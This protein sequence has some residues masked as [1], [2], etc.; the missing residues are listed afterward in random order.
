[1]P[2]IGAREAVNGFLG[3]LINLIS[4]PQPFLITNSSLR[5]LL[6]GLSERVNRSFDDDT[7]VGLIQD[8]SRRLP[9]FQKALLSVAG[10][11]HMQASQLVQ[12]PLLH[13]G[14]TSALLSLCPNPPKY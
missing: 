8:W 3:L 11:E 13:E 9:E 6:A 2:P 5:E 7:T 12:W 1:M 10:N 4:T 14:T